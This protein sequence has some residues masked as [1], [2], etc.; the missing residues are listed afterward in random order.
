[1]KQK[2]FN[3]L[4]EIK[5]VF[6]TS[7]DDMGLFPFYKHAIQ[8]TGLPVAKQPYRIPYKH[9]EWLINKM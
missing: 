2:L 3:L 8:T 1:L 9:K 5:D 7:E 6:S 4:W